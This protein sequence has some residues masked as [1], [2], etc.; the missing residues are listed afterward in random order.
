[1]FL[2]T[3]QAA[4]PIR[5]LM[6]IFCACCA[7]VRMTAAAPSEIELEF[8]AVTVPS[9]ANAGFSCGGGGELLEL[10]ATLWTHRELPTRH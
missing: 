3:A 6:P 1:M 8:A 4:T 10:G 7:E 5:S 2:A 9:F